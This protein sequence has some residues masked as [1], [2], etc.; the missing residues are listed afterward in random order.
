MDIWKNIFLRIMNI[1]D[2]EGTSGRLGG[3]S[4]MAYVLH[5]MLIRDL[6]SYTNIEKINIPKNYFWEQC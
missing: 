6:L 3:A 1:N 4:Q 2:L 5:L